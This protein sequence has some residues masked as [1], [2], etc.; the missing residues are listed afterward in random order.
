MSVEPVD[1]RIH[2]LDELIRLPAVFQP[3]QQ[4]R[5]RVTTGQVSIRKRA[6][7][8]DMITHPRLPLPER[9][10]RRHATEGG[11]I[12]HADWGAIHL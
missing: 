11:A 1:H 2:Q 3:E 6:F 5:E 10:L 7:L 9:R 12:L 4:R 8:D